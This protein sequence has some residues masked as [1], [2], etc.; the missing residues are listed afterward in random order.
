MK[1]LGIRFCSVDD[2]AKEMVSFFNEGLNLKNS[3]KENPDFF[4]GVFPSESEGSWVEVWQAS[5]QMPKGV[6]LQLIVDNADEYA[7]HAKS[8]GL[9]I[10]GPMDAHGE[11]I[12]YA[13]APNGMNVSFQSKL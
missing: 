7:A 8:K 6:M 2:N 1:L 9:E 12:Y 13:K 5:E 3:F 4:G 10:N 11:R